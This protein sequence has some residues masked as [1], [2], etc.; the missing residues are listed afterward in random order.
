MTRITV[1]SSAKSAEKF[2]SGA[3]LRS[4]EYAAE[5][6]AAGPAWEAGA[7]A[8]GPNYL[9]GISV[10]GIQER[11]VGGVKKAGAAKFARKVEKV[12]VPRYTPGI[13]A[14]KDDYKSGIEPFLAEL[15][16]YDPGDRGPRGSPTNYELSRKVGERLHNKRLALL[17]ALS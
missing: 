1:K 3:T 10:A 2:V 11:F 12:G 17:A 5:A 13:T 7:I 6:K 9:A 16:G 14:G 8:A 15:E 4:S